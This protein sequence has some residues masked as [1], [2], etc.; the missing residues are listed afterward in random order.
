MRVGIV[1]G[2]NYA[3]GEARERVRSE[4]F[5]TSRLFRIATTTNHIRTARHRGCEDDGETGVVLARLIRRSS[6]GELRQSF[7]LWAK[8]D[9]MRDWAELRPRNTPGKIA[10][11]ALEGR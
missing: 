8:S 2:W 10:C 6:Q 5:K 1:E 3:R 7:A 11:S 9:S 4:K